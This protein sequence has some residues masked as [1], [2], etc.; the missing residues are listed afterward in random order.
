[1]KV[2]AGI[3]CYQPQIDILV[4][5]IESVA[6]KVAKV[7]VVD[8]GSENYDAILDCSKTYENV[9][10][11]KNEKNIG[12]ASALNQLFQ[13]AYANGGDYVL[14]LDQDSIIPPNMLKVYEDVLTESDKTEQIAILC[15][16]IHDRITQKTWPNPVNDER[17][18]KVD[19]CIT[20]GS[21][22]NVSTWKRVGGFDEY[23][24]I[25]EVDHDYS[26]RVLKSG[27]DILLCTDVV[28]D[29]QI[30]NT[31]VKHI[32][33]KPIYVRNHSAFRKYYIVRNMLYISKKHYGRVRYREFGHALLFTLKTVVYETGKLEKIKSCLKG[34]RDGIK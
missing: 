22:N 5:C 15:P 6:N 17:I 24:F 14:C 25:D 7:V 20:S 31:E 1:M 30:G 34:F 16:K 2:F 8:N 21:L 10:L 11:I 9:E 23:L 12:V 26:Y 27:L 4:K 29:H 32:F 33:G 19:R 18:V 28:M 13:Y 3:V